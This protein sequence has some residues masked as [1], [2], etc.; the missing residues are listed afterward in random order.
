M[1]Q[2][3]SGSPV[4]S[5]EVIVDQDRQFP[6]ASQESKNDSLAKELA[7]NDSDLIRNDDDAQNI[8]KVFGG[9]RKGAKQWQEDSFF[10]YVSPNGLVWVGGVWDGHG[11][12]NGLLASN[13]ARDSA[14][15]YF[16]KVGV[17]CESWS[18]EEWQKRLKDLFY[19]LHLKIR[20]RFIHDDSKVG[21]QRTVDAL[22]IVRSPSGDPIHGGT[23]ATVVVMVKTPSADPNA[24]PAYLVTANVGDS[25]AVLLPQPGKGKME[26]L[27]VDHGPENQDEFMRV[28]NMDIE[29]RLLFVYDKAN[30]FRKYECPQVFLEDGT[31]DQA[32]VANPWGNGL[33]PTNVRYE[34][35]VYA[36]TPRCITKDSTCIA[37]T[38]ALGDFYAHQFGLTWEPPIS[39]KKL[40]PG[41]EYLILLASDGVWDCWKYNDLHL[42]VNDNLY[43][44]KLSL[45]QAGD[46]ALNESIHRA[47]TNFG[48]RHY[49]DAAL[50]MWQLPTSSSSSSS[51]VSS[52][53]PIQPVHTISSPKSPAF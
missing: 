33:H 36:V 2:C 20:E 34:P 1:N 8:Q 17:E 24:S 27:T 32:Y 9:C 45:T 11:G 40:E 39:V 13:Q 47:I 7:S 38:R 31:K 19:D 50:V 52:P 25:T 37:M 48:S 3:A 43:S 44:K 16:N 30:V 26:F 28:K 15:E 18:A 46:T 35:A 23:T 41:I 5:L 21:S 14:G 42:F 49:D 53:S 10:R 4:C 51:S 12:Y 29:N 22:G 6:K